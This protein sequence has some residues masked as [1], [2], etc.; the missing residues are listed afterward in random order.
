MTT[1]SRW[2]TT[3]YTGNLLGCICIELTLYQAGIGT[4]TIPQIATPFMAKFDQTIDMAIAWNLHAH[5]MGEPYCIAY[6]R[7]SC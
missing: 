6:H 4:Y 3:R 7:T 1:R 5:V 2:Y